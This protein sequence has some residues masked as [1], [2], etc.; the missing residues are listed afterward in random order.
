MDP[1]AATEVGTTAHAGSGEAEA[2]RGRGR[3]RRAEAESRP[4]A[5]G[6]ERKS[7]PSFRSVKIPTKRLWMPSSVVEGAFRACPSGP[8]GLVH[9]L[10]NRVCT[11]SSGAPTAS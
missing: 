5:Q 8:G 7:P 10:R 2:E 11:G 9:Y 4:G 1:D 3:R 6:A